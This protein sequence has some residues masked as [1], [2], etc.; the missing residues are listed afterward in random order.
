MG[1]ATP[2]DLATSTD[3]FERDVDII[4]TQNTLLRLLHR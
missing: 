4:T 2:P 3:V 1:V